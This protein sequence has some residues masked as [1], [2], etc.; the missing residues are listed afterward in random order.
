MMVVVLLLMVHVQAHAQDGDPAVRAE[1]VRLSAEMQKLATRETWEGVEGLYVQLLSLEKN[2]Q[3][4]TAAEHL[5]G[6]QSARALGDV[7]GTRERLEMA[8]SRGADGQI[9][10]WVSEIDRNY[11]WVSLQVPTRQR[12]D[13]A[14]S[15]RQAPFQS[16]WRFAIDFAHRAIAD[17]G[18]FVGYLP[19]GEYLLGET[20]F[21]VV[22]GETMELQLQRRR[23]VSSTEIAQSTGSDVSESAVSQPVARSTTDAAGWHG[24][25]RLGGGLGSVGAPRQA[26][27]EPLP[28]QGSALGFGLGVGRGVLPW[29]DL[30][31]E[32]DVNHVQG[33]DSQVSLGQLWVMASASYSRLSVEMGPVFGGGV[34]SAV[35][36]DG[37]LLY[38]HCTTLPEQA[39][40]GL[41]QG[42]IAVEKAQ[43]QGQILASGMAIGADV[44]FASTGAV[45][46][47]LG[48]DAGG[49][50]DGS[51]LYRWSRAALGVRFGGHP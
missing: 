42:V 50:S 47:W 4:L 15:A 39:C 37:A 35:G 21:T 5:L 34:G 38:E 1:Q 7:A 45:D 6:A 17:S 46:W 26:G 40:L 13:H 20:A 51:R 44:T 16:D 9:Q 41:E 29:L 22:A 48:L 8:I 19:A 12:D 49:L 18:V 23:R 33:T 30:G 32:L 10:D 43:T 25:M 27:I 24:R 31:A 11:G 36:V 28:F 2:G 3:A 14:L